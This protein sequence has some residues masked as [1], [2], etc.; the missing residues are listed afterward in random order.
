M[1]SDIKEIGCMKIKSRQNKSALNQTGF[2]N[3]DLTQL[4]IP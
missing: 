1:F 2:Q 3:R 4:L